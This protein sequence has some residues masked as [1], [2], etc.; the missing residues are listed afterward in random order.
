MN[1]KASETKL[2]AGFGEIGESPG[3][4]QATTDGKDQ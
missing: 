3:R 4:F 1:L 2:F